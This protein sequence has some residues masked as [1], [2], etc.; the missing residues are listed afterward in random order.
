MLSKEVQM[1]N[2]QDVPPN[3]TGGDA[4][5]KAMNSIV[6]AL[7]P[8]TKEE[9]RRVLEYVLGRFG[10]LPVRLPPSFASSEYRYERR[11]HI[12]LP[13]PRRDRRHRDDLSLFSEI[14]MSVQHVMEGFPRGA[15]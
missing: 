15:S 13:Q 3:Q 12:P 2:G 5:I 4:E 14:E 11:K 7:K 10:A 1:P 6:D 8:L 9:R